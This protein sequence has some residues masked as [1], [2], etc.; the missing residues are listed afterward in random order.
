MSTDAREQPQMTQ[1]RR[2]SR[3]ELEGILERLARAITSGDGRGAAELWETPAF[4]IGDEQVFTVNAPEELVDFFS[5]AKEQY[6]A[7]GITGT[8]PEILSA[9]WITDRMVITEVRWPYLDSHGTKQGK[10]ASTYLLRRDDSGHLRL[11]VA[12]MHGASE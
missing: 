8:Y 12:A 1:A 11:R 6:N 3:H 9:R 5:G 7:R 2:D 10:E 4:V